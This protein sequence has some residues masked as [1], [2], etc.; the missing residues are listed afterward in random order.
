MTQVHHEDT[1][2]SIITGLHSTMSNT[3]LIKL[4]MY[5]FE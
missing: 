2:H 1:E 5:L 3:I 4:A